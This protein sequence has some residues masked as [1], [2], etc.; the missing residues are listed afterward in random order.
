MKIKAYWKPIIRN[1]FIPDVNRIPTGYTKTV[2]VPDDMELKEVE[3][4]AKMDTQKGYEFDKIEIVDDN[5]KLSPLIND[6]T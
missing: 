5:V 1:P 3:D 6:K 2:E 4:F